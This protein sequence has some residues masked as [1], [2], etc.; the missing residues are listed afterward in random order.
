MSPLVHPS[1]I[2]ILNA[3]SFTITTES[4]TVSQIAINLMPLF[5]LILFELG[6]F[7]FFTQNIMWNKTTSYRNFNRCMFKLLLKTLPIKQT[8]SYQNYIASS[9]EDSFTLITI[10]FIPFS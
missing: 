1:G 10:N 4:M 2:T 8:P 5:S 6:L 7:V 9:S 3:S